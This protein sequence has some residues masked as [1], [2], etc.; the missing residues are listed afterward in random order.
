M[1]SM[2]WKKD[3]C[4]LYVQCPQKVEIG[5]VVFEFDSLKSFPSD[6]HGRR[7]APS[8]PDPR[9]L[10]IM[11]FLAGGRYVS[12][13][14]RAV[15]CRQSANSNSLLSSIAIP[16]SYPTHCYYC[17][18]PLSA[19]GSALAV[20]HFDMTRL[21]Y[22]RCLCAFI[23]IVLAV[24]FSVTNPKP[25]KNVLEWRPRP[26]NPPGDG[27]VTTWSRLGAVGYKW[28]D[29]VRREKLKE[30][31]CVAVDVKQL[32]RINDTIFET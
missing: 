1:E 13:R 21:Y 3:S 24:A 8:P 5:L 19:I 23:D 15:R 20:R 11:D 30:M 6:H 22:N 18:K 25:G 16:A 2:Q 4:I 14:L 26:P 28:A 12:A 32:K 10:C 9:L 27:W 17:L 29:I 31:P 7:H